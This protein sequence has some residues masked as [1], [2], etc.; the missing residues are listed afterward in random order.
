MLTLKFHK[1]IYKYVE[2]EHLRSWAFYTKKKVNPFNAS[3]MKSIRVLVFIWHFLLTIQFACAQTVNSNRDNLL[4]I[5]QSAD[6]EFSGDGSSTLW[7]QAKWVEL[8]QRKS[9]GKIYETS[10]KLMYSKT[11]IYALFRCEDS[12]I[13]STLDEDF[14]DLWTEDVVEI[15]FWP[16]ENLPVYFEYELSPHNCEL[17]ILVPNKEGFFLGWRPWKYEEERLTRHATSISDKENDATWSAEF[18]IPYALLKPLVEGMPK[19]GDKWRMNM[20]RLDYD[21]GQSRWAW[22]TIRT[23]FHDYESY[24]TMVFE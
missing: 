24:G 12:T 15:F 8:P 6:F 10:A 4:T 17:P 21:T 5:V 1:W 19:S 11:G 3:A 20:Y 14:A 23:N 9:D 7:Q 16:D 13:T 22:Q 2:N 18:F